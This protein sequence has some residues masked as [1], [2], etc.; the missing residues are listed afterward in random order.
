MLFC[1]LRNPP[2]RFLAR[3]RQDIKAYLC[4]LSAG[5]R[6]SYSP[7]IK[8]VMQVESTWAY[9]A[10]TLLIPQDKRR[11]PYTISTNNIIIHSICQMARNSRRD[12]LR[13]ISFIYAAS[14]IV[15][16]AESVTRKNVHK[17]SRWIIII[18]AIWNDTFQ[19]HWLTA[20]IRAN[21]GSRGMVTRLSYTCTS[22]KTCGYPRR[23]PRPGT[24]LMIT[25][26][27]SDLPSTGAPCQFKYIVRIFW[28]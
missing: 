9:T 3:V 7:A 26:A 21:I 19:S 5:G 6:L 10:R 8:A 16:G 17:I 15:S 13:S 27:H 20:V 1:V 25:R 28:K 4:P 24:L 14:E 12:S 2:P 23:Y 18:T 22:T 11:T